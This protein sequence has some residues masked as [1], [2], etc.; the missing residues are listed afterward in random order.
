MTTTRTARTVLD[1]EF[2]QIRHR[3]ID[4]GAGLDRVDR[5]FE[6]SVLANDARLEQI[7]RAIAILQD[8]QPD[9]A[10]RIQMAFSDA[11][12]PDWRS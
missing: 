7:R 2:L 10:G 4:I 12:D 1:G 3:L 8:G 11:Y 5:G 9:R 6:R